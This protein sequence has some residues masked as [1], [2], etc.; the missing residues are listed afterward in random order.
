MGLLIIFIVLFIVG[1]AIFDYSEELASVIV[2]IAIIGIVGSSVIGIVNQAN[3][4]YL[5]EYWSKREKI[6]Q[7]YEA[8]LENNGEMTFETKYAIEG[9]NSKLERNKNNQGNFFVGLF[10]NKK[11]SELDFIEIP[12]E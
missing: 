8:E 12:S 4:T 7:T 2:A 5:D 6:V 11:A 9:F 1:I 3:S 10:Y